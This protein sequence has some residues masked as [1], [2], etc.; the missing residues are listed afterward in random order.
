MVVVG[1]RGC[2]GGTGGCFDDLQA[3]QGACLQDSKWAYPGHWPR[4]WHGAPVKRRGSR[5]GSP[6]ESLPD[7]KQKQIKA[8]QPGETIREVKSKWKVSSQCLIFYN[9]Q[10]QEIMKGYQLSSQY[11]LLSRNFWAFYIVITL[12]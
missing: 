9:Q 6:Q 7:L 4:V 1:L 11:L 10:R 2:D 5:Q 8:M 3:H 12:H